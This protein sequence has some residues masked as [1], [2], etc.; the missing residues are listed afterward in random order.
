[1]MDMESIVSFGPLLLIYS[2]FFIDLAAP[3]VVKFGIES[4]F[5]SHLTLTDGF[6]QAIVDS[7]YEMRAICSSDVVILS[8]L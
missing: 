3:D 2:S 8:V 7:L 4:K 5:S 6:K 1:M